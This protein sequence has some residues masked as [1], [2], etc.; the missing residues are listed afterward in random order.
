MKS[1]LL[2]IS[3]LLLSVLTYSQK[4]ATKPKPKV[5]AEPQPTYV[6]ENE[7]RVADSHYN[8]TRLEISELLVQ[9]TMEIDDAPGLEKG[10]IKY[11]REFIKL[12]SYTGFVPCIRGCKYSMKIDTTA[13]FMGFS[14]A[15]TAYT[16]EYIQLLYEHFRPTPGK[17]M[18]R[19]Q[20]VDVAYNFPLYIKITET[21]ISD[22][23]SKF[24]VNYT[25]TEEGTPFISLD[26][27]NTDK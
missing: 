24:H 20:K 13:S 18:L 25:L 10:L 1:I 12:C 27:F 6:S 17:A 8:G 23:K 3:F 21:K 7:Q 15:G 14:A 5:V 19:G 4:T 16:Q 11:H 9:P 2:S 26:F 22:E